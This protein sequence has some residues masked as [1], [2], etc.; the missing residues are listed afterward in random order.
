MVVVVVVVVSR[1]ERQRIVMA[2]VGPEMTN[3]SERLWCS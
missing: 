1:E 2:V 3:G